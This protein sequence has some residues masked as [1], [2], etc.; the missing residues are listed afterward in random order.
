MTILLSLWCLFA[1]ALAQPHKVQVYEDEQGF[2]IRVDGEPTYLFG[3]NWSYIPVGENYRYDLF[4]QDDEI[5]EKALTNEM[6]LMKQMGVNTIR[7]FNLIPPKWVEWI[8]DNYGIYS[9]VNPLVGRY[10]VNV[11]NQYIPSTPYGDPKIRQVLID[12]T[13]EAVRPYYNTRGVLMFM[14]G[15]EANYGL[16]WE[17]F[18]IANLPKG[19][20]Q[21]AKARQLYSLYGEIIDQIHAEDDNHLVAIVNGD[22]QYLDVIREEAPNQD[23]FSANV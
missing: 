23:V 10:G 22:L 12:Q 18:E 3:M 11:D 5:I 16:V 21:E 2:Q 7:T 4:A 19:D 6:G 14:L 8:Y 9:M 1:G 13:M 15:N 20:R 17:S